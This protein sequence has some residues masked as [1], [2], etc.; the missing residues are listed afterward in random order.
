MYNKCLRCGGELTTGDF[1]GICT[2]CRN[3][4]TMEKP[5][6]ERTCE[7]CEGS[8][9]KRKEMGS[10]RTDFITCSDCGGTGIK[11]RPTTK[12]APAWPRIQDTHE[13]KAGIA[14][15]DAAQDAEEWHR[16]CDIFEKRWCDVCEERDALLLILN[17]S[18]QSRPSLPMSA[19]VEKA[20]DT[21]RGVVEHSFAKKDFDLIV[22][23]LKEKV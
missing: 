20:V 7:T 21:V 5:T 3:N 15:A 17:K 18:E 6:T 10:Y 13:W 23:A 19:E 1:D 22:A 16:L 11:P 8:G 14:A 4:Y 9:A 12:D 2:A